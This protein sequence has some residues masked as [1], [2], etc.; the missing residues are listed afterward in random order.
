[1]VVLLNRLTTLSEFCQHRVIY[2]TILRIGR[3]CILCQYNGL[4]VFIYTYPVLT[5]AQNFLR[6]GGLVVERWTPE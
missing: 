6:H 5:K 4:C 3:T 1:M 2:K